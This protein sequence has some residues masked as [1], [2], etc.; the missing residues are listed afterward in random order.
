[1]VYAKYRKPTAF[2]CEP[3]EHGGRPE[4]TAEGDRA[5]GKIIMEV[6]GGQRHRKAFLRAYVTELVLRKDTLIPGKLGRTA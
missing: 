5:A 3:G 1:M 6:A 4:S 2:V